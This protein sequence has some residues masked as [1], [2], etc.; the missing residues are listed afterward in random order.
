MK[1]ANFTKL[2]LKHHK[3]TLS[4]GNTK[5]VFTA[6][7]KK[8]FTRSNSKSNSQYQP[9]LLTTRPNYT[10]EVDTEPVIN[11]SVDSISIIKEINQLMDSIMKELKTKLNTELV[12]K[13]EQCN[14]VVKQLK[15]ILELI[16]SN[17]LIIN[18]PKQKIEE[19]FLNHEIIEFKS[20]AEKLTP[21]NKPYPSFRYHQKTCEILPYSLNESLNFKGITNRESHI[22]EIGTQTSDSN[23]NNSDY[24]T[25]LKVTNE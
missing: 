3:P 11:N 19:M 4:Q 6:F 24:V 16:R 2:P 10:M 8:S 7:V 13:S 21:R 15:F 18:R 17:T 14:G 1:K 20:R 5:K 23:E 9:P 12:N 22:S 25:S